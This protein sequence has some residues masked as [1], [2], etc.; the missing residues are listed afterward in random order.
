MVEWVGNRSGHIR[1]NCPHCKRGLG[2]K[3]EKKEPKPLWW[4]HPDAEGCVATMVQ[5]SII[6]VQQQQYCRC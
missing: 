4:I 6:T 3:H 5:H 1:S 2:G